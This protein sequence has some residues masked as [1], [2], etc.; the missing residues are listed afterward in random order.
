MEAPSGK[1]TL[2]QQRI[3]L[4]MLDEVARGE[5]LFVGFRLTKAGALHEVASETFIE[6]ESK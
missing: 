4:R 6:R 1:L 5:R 3:A 2:R